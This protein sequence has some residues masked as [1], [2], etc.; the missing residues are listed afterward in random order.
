MA[1]FQRDPVRM[2]TWNADQR[3]IPTFYFADEVNS[4]A[5]A[6]GTSGGRQAAYG[7]AVKVRFR[8]KRGLLIAMGL[9]ILLASHQ[10]GAS[11]GVR[12]DEVVELNAGRSVVPLF[13]PWKFEIGDSPLEPATH[14]PVWASPEFD[15]SKW[16]SL[17]LATAAATSSSEAGS[18]TAYVPGW[19]SRGHPDYWGYGWYRIRVRL[20]NVPGDGLALTGPTEVD[21]AYQVFAN[22]KLVGS[23]GNFNGPR[24]TAYYNQPAF[25]RLPPFEKHEE[26]VQQTHTMLIAFRVWMS[27]SSLTGSE[28]PGGIHTAPMIG[29][30]DSVYAAFQIQRFDLLRLYSPW[31][32]EAVLYTS[33]ALVAFILILFDRFDRVYLWMGSVF[34]CTATYYALGAVAV[35]TQQLPLLR[36]IVLTEIILGPLAYAGWLMVWWI[37]FGRHWPARLPLIVAILTVTYM[38]S[39]AIGEGLFYPTISHQAALVFEIVS[40]LARL[41][42]LAILVRIVVD[43]I[44]RQG[45]EGWLVLPAIVLLSVG[46]LDYELSALHVRLAWFP[47]GIRFSVG[48]IANLLLAGVLSLL[49]M[50][51]LLASVRRQRAISVSVKQMQLQSDFVAAVSH[52]FRSPLTTLRTITELLA[53][54]RITDESRRQQSYAYLEHETSRLHRLVEDL[55]DFG[56]MESGRKQYRFACHDA[57]QLVR[58]TLGEFS[59]QAEANGFRLESA[60]VSPDDRSEAAVQVDEEA[61]RRAVRNL[62]DNAMKYS[63]ECRTIWVNGAVQ[64]NKVCISVRDQGMGIAPEEQQAIFQKFVRGDAAKQAGIKGTGIGLAMVRQIVEA[65]HGE[66]R[67]TSEVGAGSTFTL[68]LPLAKN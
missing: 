58:R 8:T 66:I 36:D 24:P 30:A 17:S 51:R 20:L 62:L 44:V 54:N 16:E 22:G 32:V 60:F 5:K 50:R 19:T 52:E 9:A 59:E 61:L 48:Q 15:D 18:S 12:A 29:E 11:D 23:F 56:R 65:M 14:E 38:S 46:L 21:D 31:A 40:L 2:T 37:W 33:M 26:P 34:L 45:I 49:V 41:S 57:F 27:P 67:L 55:L 63:P 10:A 64:G 3:I 35:W 68:V 13:G 4:C 25:F 53:Q 1:A 47:F 42:F 39:F 7:R 28:G 43:A 6:A